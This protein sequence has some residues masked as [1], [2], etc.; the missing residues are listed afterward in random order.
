MEHELAESDGEWIVQEPTEQVP[1][2]STDGI[3][4]AM[5]LLEGYLEELRKTQAVSR[6]QIEAVIEDVPDL[7]PEHVKVASFTQEPSPTNLEI[8]Q[9]SIIQAM[10]RKI[11][12]LAKAIW[13]LIA[14]SVTWI[15]DFFRRMRDRFKAMFIRN[16]QVDALSAA[17]TRNQEIGVRATTLS[18]S[19][20]RK[21]SEL[22]K[23]SE[24]VEVRLR[25]VWTP[26]YRAVLNNEE[27]IVRLRAHALSLPSQIDHIQRFI[28]NLE[29]IVEGRSDILMPICL[30]H[31][32]EKRL[33]DANEQI[34][35]EITLLNVPDMADD[36]ITFQEIIRVLQKDKRDL[37]QMVVSNMDLITRQTER[38]RQVMGRQPQFS[39][40]YKRQQDHRDLTTWLEFLR[41]FSGSVRGLIQSLQQVERIQGDVIAMANSWLTKE[42]EI[43]LIY[44]NAAQ[45]DVAEQAAANHRDLQKRL[46]K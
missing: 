11:A 30:P 46:K 24:Q 39:G 35:N 20:S 15:A 42:Y 2:E 5:A 22:R 16:R 8:A 33:W 19:D 21:V 27:S 32:P 45:G 13:K 3:E 43:D 7:L 41:A 26:L 9:E 12:D 34:N 28:A 17:V 14:Q 18:P 6:G 23:Q 10:G 40:I 1:D 25:K 31:S 38:L 29:A 37:G 4:Q 44:A 36:L